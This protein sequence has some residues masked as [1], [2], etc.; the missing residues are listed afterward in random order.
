L[1][2]ISYDIMK[3]RHKPP[4]GVFL[5]IFYRI[6]LE[7][8]GIKQVYVEFLDIIVTE[9]VEPMSRIFISH[10]VVDGLLIKSFLDLLQTGLQVR[11]ADIYCTS[12][13]DID[14]GSQYIDDIKNHLRNCEVVIMLMSVNYLKSSFCLAELGGAWAL[15]KPLVP[16]LIPPKQ[17]KDVEQ[18]STPLKATQIL[19]IQDKQNITQLFQKLINLKIIEQYDLN[20]FNEKADEFIKN[21]PWKK[22][23]LIGYNPLLN[24]NFPNKEQ[25]LLG[26]NLFKP[27]DLFKAPSVAPLSKFP[28]T[29]APLSTFP[30]L[31]ASSNVPKPNNFGIPPFPKK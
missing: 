4:L 17:F 29:A 5:L 20:R 8:A 28:T 25:S 6:K 27:N 1:P 7:K 19:K 10:A 26:N 23:G 15:N 9:G 14:V 24:G 16:F 12:K 11:Y 3:I 22:K 18:P 21:E 31:S 13:G 2:R 30:P